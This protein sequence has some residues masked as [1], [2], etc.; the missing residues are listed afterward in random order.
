[1][2][3]IEMVDM[4]T[5]AHPSG[6]NLKR[7]TTLEKTEGQDVKYQHNTLLNRNRIAE[8][9]GDRDEIEDRSSANHSDA[10]NSHGI[11]GGSDLRIRFS[12]LS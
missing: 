3:T 6:V 9:F 10:R 12:L 4:P 8:R 11:K 2:L 1:M 5:S 7:N